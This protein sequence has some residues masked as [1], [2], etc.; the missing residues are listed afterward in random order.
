MRMRALPA[1]L[2]NAIRAWLATAPMPLHALAFLGL[3]T[4]QADNRRLAKGH[5]EGAR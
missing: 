2:A 3:P 4:G 1:K 5:R